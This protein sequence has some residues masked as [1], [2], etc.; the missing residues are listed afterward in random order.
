MGGETPRSHVSRPDSGE[1]WAVRAGPL[2]GEPGAR[3]GLVGGVAGESCP[4]SDGPPPTAVRTALR[5][6]YARDLWAEVYCRHRARCHT[7][8]RRRRA[9][10]CVRAPP[11]GPP[12]GGPSVAPLATP[13]VPSRRWPTRPPGTPALVRRARVAGFPRHP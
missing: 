11:D 4:G 5:L 1:A 6:R 12:A 13:R 2:H 9:W 10:W 8:R 3:G 7:S